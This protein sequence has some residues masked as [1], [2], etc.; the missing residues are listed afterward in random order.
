MLRGY[1]LLVI[2]VNH[3][4]R[5]PNV[6]QYI[7][8]QGQLWVSAAEGFFIISGVLV[9]FLY[10]PKIKENFGAVARKIIKRAGKLYLAAIGFTIG[11]TIWGQFLPAD[12]IKGGIYSLGSVSELLWRTITFDYIYGWADFLPYYAVFLVVAPAV[13]WLLVKRKGLLV[14]LISLLGWW[15]F[16]EKSTFLAW[17]ILFV[18]GITAGYFLPKI[19]E[20]L[21]KLRKTDQRLVRGGFLLAFIA[22]YLLS[23]YGVFGIGQWRAGS[24]L[25]TLTSFWFDKDTVAGGRFILAWIWFG[26]L[27][28]NLRP[29]E[30]IVDRVTLGIPRV[31]GQNSLFVYCLS[32][33]VLFPNTVILPFFSDFVQNSY[34]T[35]GVLGIIYLVTAKYRMVEQRMASGLAVIF[36]KGP[37][38]VERRAAGVVEGA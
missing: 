14:I 27:Y 18:T 10:G 12:K 4:Y 30:E 8:G 19:E 38:G 24:E 21:E 20:K 17:Q 3:L 15:F 32:A 33:I 26:A 35:A 34:L 7:S 23:V 36:G 37:Q 11:A 28:L 29:I 1:F 22:T 2:I 5:F 31:L 6:F 13:L 25:A 9:G 16:R